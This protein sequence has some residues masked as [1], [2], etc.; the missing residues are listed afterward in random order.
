MPPR[1]RTRRTQGRDPSARVPA[2]APTSTFITSTGP[3]L[4]FEDWRAMIPPLR[5]CRD[6]PRLMSLG[7]GSL[8]MKKTQAEEG[9]PRFHRP[10]LGG[11]AYEDAA[12]G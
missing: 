8:L 10:R 12:E 11:T 4:T 9:T 2:L 1:P 7:L 6:S 5:S 3:R